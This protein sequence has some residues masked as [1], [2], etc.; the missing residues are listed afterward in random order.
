MIRFGLLGAGEIA[1]TYAA[2]IASTPNAALTAVWSRTASSA[3]KLAEEYDAATHLSPEALCLSSTVDIAVIAL[4]NDAHLQATVVAADAR[5]PVVCTK[6]LGRTASES[7]RM[8]TLVEEAGIWHG[9]GESAAFSSRLHDGLTSAKSGA[10][11]TVHTV[12]I[13]EGHSGPGPTHFRNSTKTGGGALIDM[14]CHSI[15][16]A[17][18]IAGTGNKVV[19]AHTAINTLL[20]C[21][22]DR[23][24]CIRGEDVAATTLQFES[25]LLAQLT[26]SWVEPSGV[27]IRQEI[28]GTKGRDV[29]ELDPGATDPYGFEAQFRH[30]TDAFAAGSMPQQTYHD[31]LAVSQIIDDCY[32]SLRTWEQQ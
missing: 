21:E 1:R 32:R 5:C 28:I 29:R 22:P 10:L 18:L 14:G 8:L 24:A 7:R 3:K 19:A 23:S 17:L 6:P 4:P 9:Y 30:F 27:Q 11:G 25:G 20:S 26:S 31:G 12:R 2:A 15:S 16:A 13:Y